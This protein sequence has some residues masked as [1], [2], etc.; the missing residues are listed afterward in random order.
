LRGSLGCLRFSLEPSL[1][2][3]VPV[4]ESGHLFVT[5]SQK[6]SGNMDNIPLSSDSDAGETGGKGAV[7][8]ENLLFDLSSIAS[9]WCELF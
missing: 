1:T 6:H 7:I 8:Y 4:D 2:S 5:T 3:L 9:C